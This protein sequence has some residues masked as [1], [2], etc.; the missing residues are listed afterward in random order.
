MA[1]NYA[2]KVRDTEEIILE[3]R[4]L[5]KQISEI[6]SKIDNISN[7]QAIII[8]VLNGTIEISPLYQQDAAKMH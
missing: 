4:D 5:K 7:S 2:E 6:E 3:I 1:K 8:G